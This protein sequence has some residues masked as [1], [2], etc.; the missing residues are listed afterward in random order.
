MSPILVTLLVHNDKVAK[1]LADACHDRGA[2]TERHPDLGSALD[3]LAEV[4]GG[5]LFLDLAELSTKSDKKINATLSSIDHSIKVLGLGS[6]NY[7]L[8]SVSSFYRSGMYD[9]LNLPLDP[10]L[11][12]MAVDNVLKSL[13][14]ERD[15][16]PNVSAKPAKSDS[17]PASAK[18]AS[19]AAIAKG[20]Q[21]NSSHEGDNDSLDSSSQGASEISEPAVRLAGGSIVGQDPGLMK[22]FRIV[23]KVA[24]TDSTVMIHGES[25]TGKE[26]IAKAIHQASPRSQKPMIPVN[27]GAIPEELLE[28]ELFGHEKGAFTNAIR[29]RTGRF[30]MADGGTIFLDEIGDMSPKLQVK[31]LRVIQEHEFERVGGDKTISVNIRIITATHVDL[32]RAVEEG[33]FREDL[34]YRLNVIPL[35]IPPL[36]ARSGDV[37]LLVD[38]FLS[39][40][41]QTRDS[42]VTGITPEVQAVL[43]A[44][45]WPGNIR[46]LENLMERMVILAD[47]PI[48]TREDLPQRLLNLVESQSGS[49]LIKPAQAGTPQRGAAQ[50]E[51]DQ[52]G[53]SQ[54]GATQA[55]AAQAQANQAQTSQ[56]EISQTR[57]DQAD[58]TE[59]IAANI[60][61]ANITDDNMASGTAPS[62]SAI[63]G[64]STSNLQ[65]APN[66]GS[67]ETVSAATEP[68]PVPGLAP[69]DQP[70]WPDFSSLPGA[71]EE[72][73][74]L[75][76]RGRG[77]SAATLGGD[78]ALAQTDPV[79]TRTDS[80]LASSGL[81]DVIPSELRALIEPIMIFPEKGVD[82][83]ALLGDYEDRLIKAALK[84]S[85]GVK[86]QAAKSLGLSRTTFLD[87]LKKRG[88]E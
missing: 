43:K 5:A 77:P 20:S 52:A 30:E 25:G 10:F 62:K 56:S 69:Q 16:A 14:S 1:A 75:G 37:P 51:A 88:I 76:R 54:G 84:A 66:F 78:A 79:I 47:G 19:K 70:F 59:I 83:P 40:L 50:V 35:T 28:T 26:L 68:L 81:N 8:T 31:L 64:S 11:L 13:A 27:C 12:S 82:L 42:K 53:I 34:Y 65:M 57:P 29:D 73:G 7:D 39:R 3:R 6:A 60:T 2:T 32:T 67:S 21:P 61:A 86:N 22:V 23:G 17:K 41:R 33:R 48:L 38:Y 71:S 4:G 74:T 63:A 72:P 85:S 80:T 46:E 24:A 44:Y 9:Y 49:I 58:L 87:K 18:K 15:N 36:R 55:S 45:H